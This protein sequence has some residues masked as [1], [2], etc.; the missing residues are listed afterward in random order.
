M[1][2]SCLCVA[3][4]LS[5]SVAENVTCL[6]NSPNEVCNIA[7]NYTD[8][9]YIHLKP[10]RNIKTLKCLFC[11]MDPITDIHFENSSRVETLDFSHSHIKNIEFSPNN[12]CDSFEKVRLLNLSHNEIVFISMQTNC[13]TRTITNLTT[14]DLSYNNLH[15]VSPFGGLNRYTVLESLDLSHNKIVE[16]ISECFKGLSNL[17]SLKLNNNLIQT[18]SARIFL[19]LLDLVHID[20]SFNNIGVIDDNNF[21]YLEML[22]V[23]KLDHN[24]LTTVPKTFENLVSLKALNLSSNSFKTFDFLLDRL[25]KFKEIR[26]YD[27]N[28]L[29]CPQER[30]L[31]ERIEIYVAGNCENITG[32]T[33]CDLQI[34]RKLQLNE[35]QSPVVGL[36]TFCWTGALISIGIMVIMGAINILLLISNFQ[37]LKRPIH[38]QIEHIYEPVIYSQASTQNPAQKIL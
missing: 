36:K 14:L 8:G 1:L 38:M 17:Q 37:L 25:P 9:G 10:Q 11:Y 20:L 6:E 33:G 34:G 31:N 4:L 24:K 16:L 15:S 23:L 35:T 29:P 3:I 2:L 12:A 27:C 19:Y 30:I 32:G 13:L 28:A 5:K 22:E 7:Y 18:L 21:Q 26:I